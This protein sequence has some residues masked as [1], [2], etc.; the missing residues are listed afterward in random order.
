MEVQRGPILSS[1]D[2]LQNLHNLV[3]SVSDLQ[4]ASYVLQQFS[5]SDLDRKRRCERCC[6]VVK[7][8]DGSR[9]HGPPAR[10]TASSRLAST[11]LGDISSNAAGDEAASE[12]EK[13][14]NDLTLSLSGQNKP[15]KSVDP[16]IR[17]RFHPGR[18]ANRKWTCCSSAVHAKPCAGE[19]QHNPRLYG[20]GELQRNWAFYATPDPGLSCRPAAAIVIDC[21]M[22]VAV[23]GESELI[24]LSV[25]DYF[26]KAVLLD[27][28]V[29]PDVKMAHYNT[30]FS[31]VSRSTME[32]AR[33]R[34]R[35]IMGRDAARLAVWQS[36]GP[37]T[38]V[39]GHA[40]H[41]DLACLRWI[42]SLVVDTLVIER[43]RRER[44]RQAEEY[45][46]EEKARK[47]PAMS[48]GD[49]DKED[50]GQGHENDSSKTEAGLSLKALAKEKLN[51]NIQIRG[52]GHDSVEDALATR[53]LLHWYITHPQH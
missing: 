4:K 36:I 32:E 1:P 23:S 45:A 51:R 31:G 42:H 39:I 52:R 12:L 44:Q 24:R 14:L 35:C 22:G 10:T 46:K 30:R 53:D 25:I 34:K 9:V 15:E 6:R 28:L 5:P 49:G 3:L 48:R 21:E 38:I 8:G 43:K 16:V 37:E 11:G 41:Q 20:S 50:E 27:S 2:Y 19:E 13:A 40:G 18:V 7:K 26:S 33:R 47:N 17:C 29:W